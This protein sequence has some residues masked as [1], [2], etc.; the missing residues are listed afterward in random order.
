MSES[1]NFFFRLWISTSEFGVQVLLHPK[2]KCHI[3]LKKKK[4]WL[5]H[6]DVYKLK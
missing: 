5:Y 4:G 1:N 3:L 2:P 6:R